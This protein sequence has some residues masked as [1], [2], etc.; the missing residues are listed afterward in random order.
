MAKNPPRTRSTSAWLTP[1]SRSSQTLG[2]PKSP[3]PAT[4]SSP[5]IPPTTTSTPSSPP[6]ASPPPTSTASKV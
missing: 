2:P 3:L 5:M 1:P 6:P 4:A